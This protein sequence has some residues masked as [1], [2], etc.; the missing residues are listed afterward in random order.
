MEYVRITSYRDGKLIAEHL[1]IG[2]DQ[3]RAIIRFRVEYPEHN[4]CIVVAEP[5]DSEKNQDHFAI[6][7]RCGCVHFHT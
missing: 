5:Y 6:C 2:S 4:E 3:T 7:L 1:Y